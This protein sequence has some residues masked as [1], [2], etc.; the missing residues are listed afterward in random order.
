M[1]GTHISNK[2]SSPMYVLTDCICGFLLGEWHPIKL[3]IVPKPGY[4]F[5][6][7]AHRLMHASIHR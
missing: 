6:Y 4:G 2:D 5:S 3:G 7:H 1:N